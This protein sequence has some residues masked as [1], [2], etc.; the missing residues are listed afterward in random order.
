MLHARSIVVA[1]CLLFAGLATAGVCQAP[2]PESYAL[3]H[4]L[5]LSS[6]TNVREFAMGGPISCV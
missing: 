2:G 6:A 4:P 1:L 5:G 3:V